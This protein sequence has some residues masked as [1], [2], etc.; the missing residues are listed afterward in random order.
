MW[1]GNTL[2]KRR[3]CSAKGFKQLLKRDNCSPAG[4][5]R[6]SYFSYNVLGFSYNLFGFCLVVGGQYD[7][8]A[9]P[10]PGPNATLPCQIL[11]SPKLKVIWCRVCLSTVALAYAMATSASLCSYTNLM[12]CSSCGL[13]LFS[14]LERL[15]I[16]KLCIY[17]H[18]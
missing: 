17:I 11:S 3:R 6:F 18:M 1:S 13:L 2:Q 16:K 8:S 4:K 7:P 14:V 12:V 9:G 10:G 15:V 5:V